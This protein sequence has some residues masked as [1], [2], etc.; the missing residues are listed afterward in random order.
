VSYLT[1]CI[2]CVLIIG[3]SCRRATSCCSLC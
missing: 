2:C 3:S 1:V